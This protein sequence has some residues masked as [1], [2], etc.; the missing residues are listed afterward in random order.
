MSA[1]FVGGVLLLALCDGV[2]LRWI[3]FD[4]LPGTAQPPPRASAAFAYHARLQFFVVY[5]GESTNVIALNDTWV[6]DTSNSALCFVV[7]AQTFRTVV[8]GHRVTVAVG[9]CR[10]GPQCP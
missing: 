3:R 1:R 2:P 4:P 8:L 6:L 5:G 7:V 10:R 9:P